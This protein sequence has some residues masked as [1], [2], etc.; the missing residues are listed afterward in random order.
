MEGILDAAL[1]QPDVDGA[2]W[3]HAQEASQLQVTGNKTHQ[4]YYVYLT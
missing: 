2:L 1:L 3:L 4:R